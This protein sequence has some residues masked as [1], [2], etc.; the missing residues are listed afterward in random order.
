MG[1]LEFPEAAAGQHGERCRPTRCFVRS[2][3]ETR[4]ATG[5]QVCS[6]YLWQESTS[7]LV[8]TATN[9]LSQLGIGNVRLEPR[10]GA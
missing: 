10:Q 7:E 2:S 5:S 9:G 3:G 6:L 4:A 1:W 8:L